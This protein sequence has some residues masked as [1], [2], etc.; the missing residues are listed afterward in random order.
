[1]E[2]S[3]ITLPVNEVRDCLSNL[4]PSKPTGADGIPARV[5]KECS[6]QIAPSL[7]ALFNYSLRIGRFPSD[8][9]SADVTLNLEKDLPEP[10][11]N[12]RP[13]SLLP[14]VMERCVCTRLYSH[15]SQSITSLQ[16]SCVP[17]RA[18]RNL[19]IGKSLD[20]NRH[21]LYV[22]FAKALVA[23]DHA[24]LIEKLKWQGCCSPIV[25]LVF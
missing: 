11:E 5:L 14:I 17:V 21:V 12:Y 19:S 7:C 16:H 4:N 13:I 22:E 15:V 9:K 10:A 2:I 24:T 18:L 1:M 25:R 3:E 23:V 20:K 8:W 6:Q